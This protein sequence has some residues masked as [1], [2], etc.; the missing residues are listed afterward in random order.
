MVFLFHAS[1]NSSRKILSRNHYGEENRDLE[2]TKSFLFLSLETRQ[3]LIHEVILILVDMCTHSRKTTKIKL[4][5]ERPRRTP[6]P[7]TFTVSS[8]W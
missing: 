6:F 1:E 7:Q 3:P 5:I 8:G 4:V 2:T